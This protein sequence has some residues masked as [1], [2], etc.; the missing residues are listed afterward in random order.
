[1]ASNV[2]VRQHIDDLLTTSTLA[3]AQSTLEIDTS[4]ATVVRANSGA[5]SVADQAALDLKADINNPTFTGLLSATGPTVINVNS[6][7]NAL[8]ITQTGSGPA[9][10]VEDSTSPDASPFIITSD[11]SVGIGTTPTSKLQVVGNGTIAEFTGT[12]IQDHGISIKNTQASPVN[13]KRGYVHFR[14][15]YDVSVAKVAGELNTDGSAALVFHTTPSGDRSIDRD[16]QSVKIAGNGNVGVGIGNPTA[17]LHVGGDIIGSN[18]TGSSF[19]LNSGLNSTIVIPSSARVFF[20]GERENTD[21]FF[22]QRINAGVTPN[23]SGGTSELRVVLGDDPYTNAANRDSIT[24]GVSGSFPWQPKIVLASDGHISCFGDYL[25]SQNFPLTSTPVIPTRP[26]HVTT[27]SYVDEHRTPAGAIMTFAM[28]AAPTGWLYCN[29]QAV[30]RSTY[31]ALFSAIGTTYGIGNG[32]TTF[33]LPD[34]RGEF[35]R[36]W[37]DGRGIDSGRTFGSTQKGTITIVDPNLNSLNVSGI[38]SNDEDD[39]SQFAPKAGYDI[40]NGSDYASVLRASIAGTSSNVLGA[41]GFGYGATRPRNIAL[42][43]CIKY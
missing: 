2:I 42:Y 8:K 32:T 13:F 21:T 33:N 26:E 3:G 9:L 14:N 19:T 34:M 43:Y 12:S 1:M 17:K 35:V 6:S 30:N 39:S 23:P 27:K 37:D 7:L 28:S 10:L 18:I 5:W 38:Y 24:I 15:E 36:G 29:G 41:N 22:I 40:V 16:T 31:S 11:G 4:V 25:P 20:G